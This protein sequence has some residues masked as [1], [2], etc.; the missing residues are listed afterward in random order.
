MLCFAAHRPLYL[1]RLVNSPHPGEVKEESVRWMKFT[2]LSYVERNGNSR[3]NSRRVV[4]PRYS[5]NP[6]LA[7]GHAPGKPNAFIEAVQGT[8]ILTCFCSW[9]LSGLLRS[10]LHRL[11]SEDRRLS[12]YAVHIP[13]SCG[14]L[15]FQLLSGRVPVQ[16]WDRSL[17]RY[18]TLTPFLDF[19]SL[20]ELHF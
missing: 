9:Q 3:K 14:L 15:P 12:V 4:A 7:S 2:P 11:H 18:V 8:S 20:L 1:V 10:T 6:F 19:L 17:S 13:R 5:S 16:H